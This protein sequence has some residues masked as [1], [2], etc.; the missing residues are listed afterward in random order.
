[1]ILTTPKEIDKVIVGY[2]KQKVHHL[3]RAQDCDDAILRME[4]LKKALTE[5]EEI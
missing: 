4:N 2:A 5:N 3:K 1:M